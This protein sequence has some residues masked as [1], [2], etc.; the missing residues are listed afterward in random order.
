MPRPGHHLNLSVSQTRFVL[1]YDHRFDN[2]VF[3]TMH[4]QDGL[5]E[6]GEK[7]I[8]IERAGEERLANAGWNTC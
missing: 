3:S 2:R 4:N 5:S 1:I 6:P 7:I 8:V